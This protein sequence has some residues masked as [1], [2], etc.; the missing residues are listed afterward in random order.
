AVHVQTRVATA[1]LASPPTL[2][3]KI[4]IFQSSQSPSE[5]IGRSPPHAA[6]DDPVA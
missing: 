1:P 3:P 2:I 5:T 6:V 4:P